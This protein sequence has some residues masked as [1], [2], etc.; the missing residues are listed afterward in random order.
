MRKLTTNSKIWST[1]FYT[2]S[3]PLSCHTLLAPLCKL[4]NFNVLLIV[5]KVELF[6]ASF[7]VLGI[8]KKLLLKASS[9]KGIADFWPRDCLICFYDTVLDGQGKFDVSAVSMKIL[10]RAIAADYKNF[11]LTDIFLLAKLDA[12]TSFIYQQ[13]KRHTEF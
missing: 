1:D 4:Y 5:S 12:K 9:E 7:I 2:L 13:S 8:V 10:L 6:I 3:K 11:V